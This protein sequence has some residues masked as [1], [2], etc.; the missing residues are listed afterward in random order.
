MP[1]TLHQYRILL[2][3]PVAKVTVVVNWFNATF[4]ADAVPAGLGPGLSASGNAPATHNWCNGAN[5]EVNA[6]QIVNQLCTMAGTPPPADWDTMTQEERI[7]WV[8]GAKAQLLSKAGIYVDLSDNTGDWPDPEAALAAMG[9]KRI[10][11]PP[12]VAVAAQPPDKKSKK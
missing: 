10:Q 6:K 7:A 4:G 9:L 5:V 11:S 2:I 3:V 1:T 12:V 8:N